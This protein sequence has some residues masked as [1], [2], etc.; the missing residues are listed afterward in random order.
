MSLPIF[1]CPPSVAWNSSKTPKFKTIIQKYAG[2]RRKALSRQA[3]PEWEIDI[4][5]TQLDPEEYEYTIG[6]FLSV[7]G[8]F[9]AWL[10]KDLEDYKQTKVQ[11]GV[12]DGVTTGFQLLRNWRDL[13]VEPVLDIV[14]GTLTVYV[15]DV[16]V[17]VTLGDDGWVEITAP[18]EGAIV[19]A[20]FEYYWR[21]AFADDENTWVNLFTD[22]YNLKSVK[23]V[24]VK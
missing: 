18:P 15:D 9:G 4:D 16:A 7:R 2:G 1:N 6:F 14:P 3:Y 23:L 21:V 13:F 24:T 5:L 19:T 8:R 11:I 20:S 17:A 12:G 22:L 10:W